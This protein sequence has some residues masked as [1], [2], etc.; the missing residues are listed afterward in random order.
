MKYLISISDSYPNFSVTA[1]NNQALLLA[2]RSGHLDVCQH[3]LC[4]KEVR[5]EIESQSDKYY[6]FLRA[7]C[8]N[9]HLEIFKTFI[10]FRHELS[11]VFVNSVDVNL[12]LKIAAVG[13][14]SSIIEYISSL[15]FEFPE[16][17]IAFIR[18]LGKSTTFGTAGSYV[19]GPVDRFQKQI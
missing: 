7:S 14:Y 16:L 12:C 19:S 9:G 4:F 6:E 15:R 8:Q 5:D 1:K 11:N 3:L 17:D 2:C 13:S 10:S 18:S